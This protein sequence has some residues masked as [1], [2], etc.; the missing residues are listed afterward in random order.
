MFDVKVKFL[1]IY[2]CFISKITKTIKT[3]NRR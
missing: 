3:K 2:T 1:D